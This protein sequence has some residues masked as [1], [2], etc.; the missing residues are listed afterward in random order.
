MAGT[1][2]AVERHVARDLIE[3]ELIDMANSGKTLEELVI[4]FHK[5]YPEEPRLSRAGLSRYRIKLLGQPTAVENEA[6]EIEYRGKTYDLDKIKSQVDVSS[7][8]RV[9]EFIVT[10]GV[11][12]ILKTPEKVGPRVTTDALAML[13]Q[14]RGGGNRE[15][16][17]REA[18]LQR[19]GTTVVT[20]KPEEPEEAEW[21]AD[22][23]PPL[24]R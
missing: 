19:H 3:F 10:V 1:K 8:E 24:P 15:D 9:L 13:L 23:L 2:S 16:E 14:I 20:T 21:S 11:A 12:N 7:V 22:D 18:W 17:L 5:A 4:Q 6:G